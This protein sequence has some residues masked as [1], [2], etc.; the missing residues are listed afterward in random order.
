M[1]FMWWCNA[2][3]DSTLLIVT[4]YMNIQED[5]HRGEN[6]RW[7]KSQKNEPV[8]S[9]MDL[10]ADGIFRGCDQNG[11]KMVGN[12]GFV[13]KQLENQNSFGDLLLRACPGCLGEKL[14]ESW[15]ADYIVEHTPSNLIATILKA[16]R[17]QLNEIDL[18]HSVEEIATPVPETPLEYDQIL[19]GGRFWDD[20]DGGYLP[21]DLALAARR[22]EIDWIHSEGVYEIV[23]IHECK[24][25]GM[26]LLDLNWVD[27]DKSV[28]P[29]RKKIR[30]R[31]CAREY[32]TKKQR[33]ILS[34]LW[35]CLSQS[36]CRWVC[37]TKGKPL[38]LR[39]NDISR[40]HFQGTAQRFIYIKLPAEDR[41]KYGEDM[42]GRLIRSM[43]G[44]QDA[45]TS[46]KSI[47]WI[48]S[49]ECQEAFEEA[50]TAQHCFTIRFK[51]WGLQFLHV[52]IRNPWRNWHEPKHFMKEHSSATAVE[53]TVF[54][55]LWLS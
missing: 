47:M 32:K 17:E 53:S 45:P 51:M 39:H 26:K 54:L 31:L 48:W 40:A 50:N 38:K 15:D 52:S 27:T 1:V 41:L 12:N 3:C 43:Y 35:R 18:Q 24:D 10:Y 30:S 23:P 46:G 8:T 9:W 36:W 7:Q 28:V 29:T 13:H 11:V 6:V 55:I 49:V 4:G 14:D 44:I 33:K 34:K 37:R 16:L 21:E 5:M 2:S 19:K 22:E 20:V 42:V 25:S